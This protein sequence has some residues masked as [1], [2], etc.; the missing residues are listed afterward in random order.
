MGGSARSRPAAEQKP[1]TSPPPKFLSGFAAHQKKL[2]LQSAGPRKY[3]KGSVIVRTGDPATHLFLVKRGRVK[4]YRVTKRGEEVLLWWLSPGDCF[5][6]GTLFAVPVHYIGTAQAVE[7]CELVV[8]NRS[9]IR[10]LAAKNERLGQNALHIILDCLA[11]FAERVV[12][13]TTE[14]AEQRLART[15]LQLGRRAGRVRR[16]H[17]ELDILNED[18][19]GL[20]DVSV[21]TASRQLKEWE[22]QGV[23]R[24][25][26]GHVHILSPEG[27]LID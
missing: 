27:L 18:L 20:S 3:A 13:Q 4:F 6:I 23:V 21:F 16:D 14:T 22:R 1:L 26:R 8:W 7:D 2:I 19:A 10:S 5:G 15:L 11:A 17:I 12:G 9:T 24:K 25:I